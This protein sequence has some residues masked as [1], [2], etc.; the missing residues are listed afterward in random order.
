M[1]QRLAEAADKMI[2]YVA[3]QDAVYIVKR[4]A[5][6]CSKLMGRSMLGPAPSHLQATLALCVHWRRIIPEGLWGPGADVCGLRRDR[7]HRG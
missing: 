5:H 1:Q 7:T 2:R 3:R 4:P 6:H